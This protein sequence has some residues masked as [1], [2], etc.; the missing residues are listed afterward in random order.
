MKGARVL[1]TDGGRGSAVA[2][3]RSL[4]RRGMQVI[5]SDCRLLSPGLYSNH[6][7]ERLQYPDPTAD[8]GAFVDAL[9]SASRTFGV[10]LVIPVT[11]EAI[12]PLARERARFAD[13]TTLALPDDSALETLRDK[14]KTVELARKLGVPTPESVSVA[15]EDEAR[16]RAGALGWPVVVKPRESRTLDGSGVRAGFAVEYAGDEADLH[17]VFEEVGAGDGVLLQEYCAGE[18]HGVGVLAAAGRPLAA[19]QHRRL[20][21]VPLTGGP[22]S[23]RESVPLDPVLYDYSVRLLS[24]VSWTG[25]AMVEFKVGRGRPTL[26]E[27]NGRIW[28]SFA[29][30]PRSGLD[31]AG[32][33]A[34]LYLDGPPPAGRRPR[35]VY[36]VGIRL[37]DLKLELVW[38]TRVLGTST[39][40]ARGARPP[41]RAAVSV[42]RDLIR[43]RDG[44]DILTRD[45][46]LPGVVEIADLVVAGARNGLAAAARPVARRRR[47]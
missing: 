2:V 44:F 41:R 5:A 43:G 9:L 39:T 15:T 38:L 30:A 3:I 40:H 35:T 29:L 24:A 7:W 28:G 1:V 8:A 31:L 45:D 42:L 19:F 34:E 10:D 6:R 22:S 47:A 36:D 46:P 33:L 26:M 13:V 32:M 37:H 12:L 23:F 21:E 17:R 18:G 11:D 25:L 20:R 27:I 16:E 4:A 14:A